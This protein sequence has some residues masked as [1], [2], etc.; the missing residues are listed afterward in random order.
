MHT[1]SHLGR[2][3]RASTITQHASVLSTWQPS[4]GHNCRTLMS[5]T[6]T[7][8]RAEQSCYAGSCQAEPSP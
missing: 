8:T 1:A 3:L 7:N 2:H 5:M 6:A 4:S